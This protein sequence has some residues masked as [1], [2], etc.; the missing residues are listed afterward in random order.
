M[1]VVCVHRW[2]GLVVNTDYQQQ[3]TDLTIAG[4]TEFFLGTGPSW[5][6]GTYS[7]AAYSGAFTG[8]IS[9]V[10]VNVGSTG[11]TAAAPQLDTANKRITVV[12]T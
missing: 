10:S 6:V 1:S 2:K 4:P 9:D 3:F 7:L 11:R 8:S 12:L 5:V